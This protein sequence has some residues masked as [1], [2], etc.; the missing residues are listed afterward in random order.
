MVFS[1]TSQRSPR[2]PLPKQQQAIA[3]LCTTICNGV[4]VAASGSALSVG[5]AGEE[6]VCQVSACKL[7]AR[8]KSCALCSATLA[9]AIR[10]SGHRVGCASSTFAEFASV[11]L[12]LET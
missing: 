3:Y 2:L 7:H 9:E 10:A 5:T 11:T 8:D 4:S 1:Q 6:A 12:L